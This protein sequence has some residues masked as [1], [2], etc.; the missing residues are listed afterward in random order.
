M[1]SSYD[2]PIG[3]P[4]DAR[5]VSLTT[6]ERNAFLKKVY[7]LVL[8]GLVCSGLGGYLSLSSGAV[9]LIP[10]HPWISMGLFFGLF[11]A[12]NAGRKTPGLNI[13]LLAAFTGFSGV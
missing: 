7:G 1:P 13:A 6:D 3:L 11:F 9:M 2:F 4:A 5:P 10:Q 8:F 12:A